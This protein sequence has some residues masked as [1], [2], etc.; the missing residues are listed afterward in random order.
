M[1]Q[2]MRPIGQNFVFCCLVKDRVIKNHFKELI[3]LSRCDAQSIYAS[4]TKFLDKHATD[5]KNICFAALD[6]CSTMSEEH[7]N[8]KKTLWSIFMDGVQLPQ[9]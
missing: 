2:L 9:G 5:I 6:G 7:K 4:V 3:P 1:N 8:L